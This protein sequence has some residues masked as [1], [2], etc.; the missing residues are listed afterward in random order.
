LIYLG[1]IPLPP[2]YGNDVI[3]DYLNNIQIATPS[4][5]DKAC[6]FESSWGSSKLSLTEA[7]K[8]LCSV[9]AIDIGTKAL[10]ILRGV[11]DAHQTVD[12]GAGQEDDEGVLLGHL[13]IDIDQGLL[14]FHDDHAPVYSYLD[15]NGRGGNLTLYHVGRFFQDA[16][17]GHFPGSQASTGA[18]PD[19]TGG[20][21]QHQAQPHLRNGERQAAYRQGD[22]QASGQGPTYDKSGVLIKQPRMAKVPVF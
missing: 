20:H 7:V 13:G 4:T 8:S 14:A 3:A 19:I 21:D 17:G 11:G 9:P 22:S 5:F 18:A 10:A 15:Y 1:F 16:V 2:K 12:A 6:G